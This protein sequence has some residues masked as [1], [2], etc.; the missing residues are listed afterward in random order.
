M[1]HDQG[2]P[3]FLWAEACYTTVYLQNKSAHREVGIMTLEED[4]SGKKPEVGNFQIFGCITYSHV[5]SE[6]RTNIE[7]MIER[8]IFVG[9]RETSKDFCIYIPSLRKTILRRTMPLGSHKGHRWVRSDHL[10]FR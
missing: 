10:I 7:P 5:P 6:K 4:F 9:Y 1:L 3:L 2:L 8:G